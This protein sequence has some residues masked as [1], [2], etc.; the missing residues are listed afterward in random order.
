MARLIFKVFRIL[1]AKNRNNTYLLR[2]QQFC[3]EIW[4]IITLNW[5]DRQCRE[6]TRHFTQTSEYHFLLSLIIDLGTV[7]YVSFGS[8]NCSLL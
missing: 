2:E 8:R 6:D 1:L 4:Y 5:Y 3:N 7:T